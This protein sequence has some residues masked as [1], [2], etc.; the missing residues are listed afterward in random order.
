VRN[1]F[2]ICFFKRVNVYRY[3]KVLGRPRIFIYSVR[4]INPGGAVHE[5]ASAW[6]STLEA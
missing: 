3:V 4:A 1:W 6:S 5:L 2:Q